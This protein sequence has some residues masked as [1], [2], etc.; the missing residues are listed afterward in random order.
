MKP[1]RIGLLGGTFNPIHNGHLHI[2]SEVSKHLFLD[3]VL[4][5]PSGLP[6]HKILLRIPSA[7][8]RFKMVELALVAHPNFEPCDIEIKRS[9]FSY[10]LET[11][12]AL[13]EVHSHDRLFFIIGM[14]AF[15]QIETWKK[16]EAVL[17]L[18]DFAVISRPG[19]PF[20]MLPRLGPLALA[21]Q[22]TLKQL[23]AGAIGTHTVWLTPKTELHLI[24]IPHSG[25]SASDIRRRI[26][27]GKSAKN[28]LPHSVESYII[29]SRLY[30]GDDN[31]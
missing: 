5:I 1:R 6:P 17:K 31:F 20:S 9:G 27:A 29:N 13:K 19:F 7:G 14:D 3:Q 28:L 11:L 15:S 23:D 16:P 30:K 2:A 26:L 22:N 10:T 8:I 12:R 25:I 4:F 21:D 18:C 24:H